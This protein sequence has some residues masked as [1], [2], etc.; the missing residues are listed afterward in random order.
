MTFSTTRA[1]PVRRLSGIFP[2][3]GSVQSSSR[4][5]FSATRARPVRR[6]GGI[7]PLH[8]SVHKKVEVLPELST[9]LICTDDLDSLDPDCPDRPDVHRVDIAVAHIFCDIIHIVV[10]LGKRYETHDHPCKSAAVHTTDTIFD[11]S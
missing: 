2:L 3:H 6:T 8:G 4:M 11:P 9:F 1:R 5:T 7:F 10:S